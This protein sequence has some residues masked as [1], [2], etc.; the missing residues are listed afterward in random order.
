[1]V[2]TEVIELKKHSSLIAISNKNLSI[3]QR[4]L[5]NAILYLAGKQ[6]QDDPE[7]E[8]F[9]L[10]FSD[11]VKF[12]SYENFTNLKY[13]KDAIDS[14]VETRINFNILEKD[15]E[16]FWSSFTLISEATI[17]R[18]DEFI[19]VTFPNL[20][21]KNIQFPTIYALL[22]LSIV[23][24]LSAKYSLPLYEILSDYKKIGRVVIE[25]PKFRELVGVADD[26]YAKF[27][28]FRTR[29]VESSVS[30]I[31]DKTDLFVSYDF[32]N[33]GV[34]K[35]FTHII[36]K[37][38]D[39]YADLNPIESSAYH[40]L[41]SKGV[42]DITAKRFSKQLSK[43]S[44][45]EAIDNLERAVKK[46]SVKNVAAYL[47]KI[48]KN[49][50]V[51]EDEEDVIIL[52]HP[53][54]SAPVAP[55]DYRPI[56]EDPKNN[57]EFRK[58]I[59]SRVSETISELSVSTFN[60]F[61]DEQNTFTLEYYFSKNILDESGNIVNLAALSTDLIFRGWVEKNYLDESIEH[62]IYSEARK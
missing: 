1:M 43:Q 49:V 14:L 23:N 6:I 37:I 56:V 19:T 30:D 13:L 61:I 26:E 20:I 8:T 55:S 40:L 36:F 7:T 15:K 57:I 44:I 39:K 28:H 16:Q 52:E 2:N 21:K 50:N 17:V 47:T 29:V 59:S 10:K 4:K 38:K 35:Q 62:K 46:G 31:N 54:K 3:V 53:T 11:V 25:I 18:G 34:G 58:Y 27:G 22:N 32:D 42:A 45:V 51:D 9:R 60:K 48:L 12:S 33:R 24:N 41:K 5:Y